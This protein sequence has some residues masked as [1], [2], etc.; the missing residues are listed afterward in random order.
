MNCNH[1]ADVR[2]DWNQ[3]TDKY[4]FVSTERFS[5]IVIRFSG[6]FILDSYES[7]RDTP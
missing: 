4:T 2:T 1:N 7:N 6:N 3:M 5:P